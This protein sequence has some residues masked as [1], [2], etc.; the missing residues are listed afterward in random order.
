MITTTYLFKTGSIQD[1][2]V[3]SL[4]NE[5]KKKYST[6]IS[7]DSYDLSFKEGIVLNNV[8]LKDHFNDTLVYVK[9]LKTN[10]KSIQN[11]AEGEIRFS[12]LHLDGL[13]INVKK[14]SVD[15]INSLQSFVKLLKSKKDN[16]K[17]SSIIYVSSFK[18]D[19]SEIRFPNSNDFFK[20]F[21]LKSSN[22]IVGPDFIESNF[23]NGE[24]EASKINSFYF[25]SSF[26]KYS[27]CSLLIDDYVLLSNLGE[28]Y[29][30]AEYTNSMGSLF[31]YIE[32][33]KI[34]SKLKILNFQPAKFGLKVDSVYSVSAELDLLGYLDSINIKNI[35]IDLGFSK[36]NGEVNILNAFSLKEKVFSGYLKVDELYL[37]EIDNIIK[38]PTLQFGY[39]KNKK[40]KKFNLEGIYS[41][42]KWN[43][44]V[45]IKSDFGNFSTNF[46]K[47]KIQ[48]KHNSILVDVKNLN[49][50]KLNKS[51]PDG[52]ISAKLNL[53]LKDSLSEWELSKGY[54]IQKNITPISFSANGI[55]DF[56]KGKITW[57]AS[58]GLEVSPS[59]IQYDFSTEINKLSSVLNLK[60]Y[61]LSKIND[62]IGGG[63]AVLSGVFKGKI[64]GQSLDDSSIILTVQ[65]LQLNHKSGI[66]KSSDFYLN[67]FNNNGLRNFSIINSSWLSG[68]AI[69]I[70][71]LS[72][73]KLLIN[74]VLYETFPIIPKLK[75]S[76]TQEVKFDFTLS[77]DLV[78]VL[79]TDIQSTEDFNLVGYLNNDEYKSYLDIEVPFFQYQDFFAQGLKI[80]I[81]NKSSDRDSKLM[82]NKV[83]YK[84]SN[85]GEFLLGSKINKNKLS[86]NIQLNSLIRNGNE[87]NLNFNVDKLKNNMSVFN[88]SDSSI[89]FNDKM[90]NII[91][92]E[93]QSIIYNYAEKS[94]KI[95]DF[96]VHSGSSLVE[97]IGFYNGINNFGLNL[98]L[99]NTNLNQFLKQKKNFK[100]EGK[101]NSVWKIKKTP[102]EYSLNGILSSSE[103][104]V[105]KFL[106]G[107]LN[108]NISGNTQLNLFTIDLNIL[109]NEKNTFSGVGN[110]ILDNKSSKLDMDI[111]F[112]KFDISFLSPLG[113]KSISNI[114]GFLDGNVNIWGDISKLQNTG[115]LGLSNSGFSIPYLNTDYILSN[116][117]QINL[118]NNILEFTPTDLIDLIYNTKASI[119]AKFSHLNFKE[120]EM[121]LIVD[122]EGILLLNKI[123]T[124]DALFYGEGFLSG[125]ILIKGPIKNPKLEV[126]GLT[127][128][129]TSIKI[130][131]KDTQEISDISFIKFVDKN[132][133]KVNSELKQLKSLINED[134]GLE[135]FFEL[136]IND[137]ATIEIVVDQSSGSYLSGKGFGKLLMES[138]TKKKF[139]IWGD[140]TT[141]SGVYNFKNLGLLDKKFNLEPGGTIVWDGNPVGAQMDLNAL[142]QVPGGA[143]PAIL[144]DNPNFNKKI[145]TEV[146]I[147][148]QGNL[149]KP[150]NPIFEIFF[151]NTNGTVVSEINYRLSD[152]QRSQLQAIS[153]LSQGMFINEVS[154]SVEGITNNLYEKASDIF[155]SILG[156]SEEKLKVGINY[157]QGDNNKDLDVF[158]EDRLGLTLSTQISD[159]ILINGKIGV[160]IGG[161]NET[162]IVGDVQIDFILNED[163][164]LKA[165]V[166]NKENEFRYIG[167]KL[168][169]TQGMGLS[170]NV[171]FNTF[172]ELINKIIKEVQ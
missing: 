113:K 5:V 134:T 38:S 63:K 126:V 166:F 40:I 39:L 125:D 77:K 46:Y 74:N 62:K 85:L 89:F 61:N 17:I 109:N 48:K 135:M 152:P 30:S 149:L 86:I 151:P 24:F 171:D 124:S 84:S 32:K 127:A 145:P 73:T 34:K 148:L 138:N 99:Q 132:S 157:L 102:T 52:N 6:D 98:N 7:F 141:L 108:L 97:I 169:Y 19:N 159:K 13:I 18:I 170:Y 154:F 119:Q 9:N 146:G 58:D 47:N 133:K 25:K 93:N 56:K 123:E 140:F 67:S 54:F 31:N 139:N 57:S 79:N 167:D 55:G 150:D 33:P 66:L 94:F 49:L 112:S 95:D 42:K 71:D 12:S 165:K 15:K 60:T 144:L 168:G 50:S 164:S 83:V 172:K 41:S 44:N 70:F 68:E 8:L 2:V 3:Q 130:P 161:V 155:T 80:N 76:K 91:E 128:P 82:I 28:L 35:N 64:E 107:K 156:D 14:Y 78:N 129:G 92:S 160:P 103:L 20:I 72:K 65:N 110:F 43:L 131:W 147:H 36:I 21:K 16:T 69:G 27:G 104:Y 136:D 120:W 59:E 45:D 153:L 143:N 121:D 142:Y 114:R 11:I 23:I 100:T 116:E 122:S 51:I 90:W 105:N 88:F 22:L 162:L 75:L 115:L 118:Y 53:N 163:G 106:V 81:N 111:N 37:N 101:F 10:L 4:I 158:S 1:K 117:T 29:G 96:K 26:F 137:N 87:F